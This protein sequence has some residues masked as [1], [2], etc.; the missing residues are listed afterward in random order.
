[1]AIR[2]KQSN[3]FCDPLSILEWPA[4]IPIEKL[5]IVCYDSNS[6]DAASTSE[7]LS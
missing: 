4:L 7:T 2:R 6:R 5:M 1:M 3:T